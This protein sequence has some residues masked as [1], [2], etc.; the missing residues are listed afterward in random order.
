MAQ[1]TQM[2][3]STIILIVNAVALIVLVI[4]TGWYASS[5]AKTLQQIRRQTAALEKQ[6]AATQES[7]ALLRQATEEQKGIG[8]MIVTSTVQS[9]LRTID[10]W[11]NT[12]IVNLA[13]LNALPERIML[14]PESGRRA[15]EHARSISA[16]ATAELA[17]ALDE[18]KRCE[19]EFEIGRRLYGRP[20]NEIE[21][22]CGRIR[23]LLDS[24]EQ[25][26]HRSLEQLQK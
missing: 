20:G 13:F 10:Y 26:L 8:R 9:G 18:V 24:A 2:D 16:E 19:E 5:T 14:V 11:K 3:L 21:K 17:S 23:S 25:A 4:I 15:V 12:N 6:T 1:Q 7:V 22:Q